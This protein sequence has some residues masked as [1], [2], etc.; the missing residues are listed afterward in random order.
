MS[1]S[2]NLLH[3]WRSPLGKAKPARTL[4]PLVYAIFSS[5]GVRQLL[6]DEDS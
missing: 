2:L 6:A 5:T 3:A 1:I 4:S